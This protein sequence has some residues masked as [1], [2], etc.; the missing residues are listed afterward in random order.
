MDIGNKSNGFYWKIEIFGFFFHYTQIEPLKSPPF[1]IAGVGSNVFFRLTLFKEI[2]KKEMRVA[3]FLNVTERCRAPA[4]LRV[5]GAVT[6]KMPI[7]IVNFV[8]QRAAVVPKLVGSTL[9]IGTTTWSDT[10]YSKSDFMNYSLSI[11]LNLRRSPLFGSRRCSAVTHVEKQ[12]KKHVATLKPSFPFLIIL[13]RIISEGNSEDFIWKQMRSRAN[14][15]AIFLK[16]RKYGAHLKCILSFENPLNTPRRSMEMQHTFDDRRGIIWWYLNDCFPSDILNEKDPDH[17]KNDSP[18]CFKIEANL[19]FYEDIG[20]IQKYFSD[21]HP[22]TSKK[23]CHRLKNDLEIFFRSCRKGCDLILRCKNEDFLVHKSLLCCKSPVFSM[24]FESDMKEKTFGIVEME[25][26]DS[27]TLSRFIEYLYL[28]SVTDSTLDLDSATALYALAHR[29]SIL[30]LV[31]W[32]R[33]FLVFNMEC[34]NID[35]M[36]QFADLYDDKTLKRLINFCFFLK[37]DYTVRWV[38]SYYYQPK[39][40]YFLQKS[41]YFQPDAYYLN[42]EY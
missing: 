9:L 6:L 5:D 32:S 23:L 19:T 7:G 10:T 35:E 30:N 11:M 18:V 34:G 2:R 33:Q 15:I 25:G 16:E 20:S 22:E 8:L 36:M 14:P 12:I 3:C 4:N 21:S 17:F 38:G 37:D 29:Y 26:V 1:Q 42:N 24:M 27:L 13:F 41:Y 40:Y 28:G 31:N 39:I